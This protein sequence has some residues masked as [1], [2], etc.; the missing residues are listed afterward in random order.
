MMQG[1]STSIS[2]FQLLEQVEMTLKTEF[3][4]ST[5][6]MAEILELHVNQRGHCY[7]ELIEKSQDNDAIIAKAR[8]TIWAAKFSMLKPFFESTTGMPLKSGIKIL[9]RGSVGFHPVYGFGINITD[10]DKPN[11]GNVTSIKLKHKYSN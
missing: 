8:A 10:I 5:W 11:L 9:C 1:E 2:L 3:S 4:T 6:F 7:I